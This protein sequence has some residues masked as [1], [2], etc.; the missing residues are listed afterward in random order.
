MVQHCHTFLD[1]KEMM[2]TSMLIL[3]EIPLL[4]NLCV[5]NY[6][7]KKASPSFFHCLAKMFLKLFL[8]IFQTVF[9]N[10]LLNILFQLVWTKFTHSF[11][12]LFNINMNNSE[13]FRCY[14]WT[15]CGPHVFLQDP[16][17][18]LSPRPPDI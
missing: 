16:G 3:K 13:L 18:S 4:Q 8:H 1:L 15:Y 11:L 5:P 9:N 7:I 2:K 6:N 17:Y 10:K 14:R 12:F